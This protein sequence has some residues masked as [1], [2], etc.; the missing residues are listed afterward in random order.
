MSERDFLPQ[1]ISFGQ[2]AAVSPKTVDFGPEHAALQAQWQAL[3]PENPWRLW[4]E[5]DLTACESRWRRD[6]L[7]Q[8]IDKIR[9]AFAAL[10]ECVE[11]PARWKSESSEEVRQQL[12]TELGVL[13][14]VLQAEYLSFLPAGREALLPLQRFATVQLN[15]LDA[16]QLRN[17]SAYE[18]SCETAA[19]HRLQLI[20]AQALPAELLAL[21][22]L[23]KLLDTAVRYQF[24]WDVALQAKGEMEHHLT[25]LQQIA[26]TGL[27]P[28]RLP[29]SPAVSGIQWN[30]SGE[31]LCNDL[32]VPLRALRGSYRD[33]FKQGL[34]ALQQA[35]QQNFAPTALL[36]ALEAFYCAH[37]VARERAEA[38]VA[39]AWLLTLLKSPVQAVDC[40]E[41]ALHR[42]ALPEIKDLFWQIQALDPANQPRRRKPRTADVSRPVENLAR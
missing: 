16:L 8:W 28:P 30:W 3:T 36:E 25:A 5:Q 35:I 1:A 21:A 11:D 9:T 13:R 42:E 14:K 26:L 12:L 39:I 7:I 40:L 33:W 32:G 20:Q 23:D 31:Q 2:T 29:A 19:V 22:E 4:L 38:L 27:R 24:A 34:Y 6:W 18:K 37:S 15:K 10:I 41:L 17:A